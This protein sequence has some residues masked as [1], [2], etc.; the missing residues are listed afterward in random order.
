MYEQIIQIYF[1]FLEVFYG[2]LLGQV[3]KILNVHLSWRHIQ[4]LYIVSIQAP[5]QE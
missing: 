2:A 1:A 4:E 3:G 5:E